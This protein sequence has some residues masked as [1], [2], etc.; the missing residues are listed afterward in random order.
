[1]HVWLVEG[2]EVFVTESRSLAPGTQVSS[3]LSISTLV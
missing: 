3:I 1:M 2:L